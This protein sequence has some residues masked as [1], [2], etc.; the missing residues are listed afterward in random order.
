M[1]R[2]RQMGISLVELLVA[3][4]LLAIL[5][6]ISLPNFQK[7]VQDNKDKALRNLLVSQINQTR[8]N[9]II[10]NRPHQLCGS[11]DGMN[12]NGDWGGY[13]LQIRTNA[14]DQLLSQ[15]KAPS[16]NLCWAGFGG[17]H[18]RFQPNGTSPASNGR[19]TICRANGEHWQLTLNRQGRIR[20]GISASPRGCCATD[21]PES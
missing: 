15:H 18:I 14:E 9:A 20:Q 10:H 11:S 5:L 21:H 8:T 13:W 17:Q 1:N 16:E 2:D 7:F 4:T 19:F 12:C 6:S 3:I